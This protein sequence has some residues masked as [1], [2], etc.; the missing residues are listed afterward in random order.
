MTPPA[1]RLRSRPAVPGSNPC[2][3][4][5]GGTKS[6]GKGRAAGMARTSTFE[7]PEA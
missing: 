5:A 1:E 4:E 3:S 6:S 7:A 2:S